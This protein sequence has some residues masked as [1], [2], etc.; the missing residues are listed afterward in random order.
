MQGRTPLLGA[1]AAFAAMFFAAVPDAVQA[2]SAAQTP[3]AITGQVSSEAEGAMEGVVVSAR[4]AGS[5][6]TVSV[7][8]NAQGRYSFPADRL[9]AGQYALR[10]RAVGYELASPAKADVATEQTANVDLK[11]R[12]TKNLAAQ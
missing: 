3:A 4:K 7:T 6:V 5:T 9:E 10:I 8:T 12:K 2:Q 11:L 1:G